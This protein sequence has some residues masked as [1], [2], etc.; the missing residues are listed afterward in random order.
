MGGSQKLS[1]LRGVVVATGI[2]KNK[3]KKHFG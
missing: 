1:R 2:N 3:L